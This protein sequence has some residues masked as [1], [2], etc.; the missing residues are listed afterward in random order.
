VL[1]APDA[2][3]PVDARAGNE[4]LRQGGD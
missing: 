3:L 4:F 2:L 1:H